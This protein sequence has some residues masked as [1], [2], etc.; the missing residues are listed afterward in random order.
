MS[1]LAS[2]PTNW[3]METLEANQWLM[4]NMAAYYPLGVIKEVR[5]DA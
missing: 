4:E 3:G 5:E 2:C 1:V